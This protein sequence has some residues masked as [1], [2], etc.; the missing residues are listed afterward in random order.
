MLQIYL[1]VES[2][3][4]DARPGK[5]PI[6]AE[7]AIVGIAP[8]TARPGARSNEPFGS[9][10][11]KLIE[12]LREQAQQQI[13]VTNM[14][15]TPLEPGKKPKIQQ[16]RDSMPGLL[17]ELRVVNPKRILALGA[18]VAKQLCPDFKSMR[19]DHGTFFFNE[20]LGAY[21]IPTYHFSATARNPELKPQLARDLQRFF[22]LP[23]P[24]KKEYTIVQGK[25]EEYVYPTYGDLIF[26]DIETTGFDAAVHDILS[27]GFAF[28]NLDH[29]FIMP[30]PS[31]DHVLDLYDVV[32]RYNLTVVGHNLTFDLQFL[33]EKCGQFWDFPVEDTMIMAYLTGEMS[34]SLKHLTSFY[35]DRPGSRAFGSFE[36]FDYLTEDVQSTKEIYYHFDKL[37]GDVFIRGLCHSLVPTLVGMRRRGIY[38]DRELL[39]QLREEYIIRKSEAEE[40]ILTAFGKPIPLDD[41]DNEGFNVNSN[42]QLAK[43]FQERGIKL[44]HT[45]K[46]GAPSLAEAVMVELSEEYEEAKLVL[47]YRAISKYLSGFIEGYLKLTTDE[48]PILHPRLYLTST[49]TGRL[50]CSD[51]NLQQVPRVGPLKS[52][53][54]SR[55]EG[56]KLGL[57]DFSQA[58]LRVVGI[59]AGDPEFLKMVMEEDPHRAVAA[60]LFKKPADQVTAGERKAAKTTNFALLYQSTIKSAA[61]KAGI[62]ER[63]M[64][65]IMDD[66]FNRFPKL[67]RYI[68]KLKRDGIQQQ[69]VT[70]I[71]GRRRD[72]SSLIESEGIW[73]AQRKAV[74]TPIQG[75]ASDLNLIVVDY[76]VKD[77]RRQRLQTR[78]LITIHDSS[79][80]EIY[81]GE[82][83]KLAHAVQ[84]G[85]E[86]I[87]NSPIGELPQA[88]QVPFVGELVV[89]NSWAAIESTNEGYDKKNNLYFPMSSLTRGDWYVE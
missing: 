12:A 65:K 57:I 78:P 32:S 38:I 88:K 13:Y 15:K 9:R 20:F 17:Y 2:E 21:V 41:D 46:S 51:P 61:V 16:I 64:Q 37:L 79:M 54:I 69:Y 76:V 3:D 43:A 59:L 35:L 34:L 30:N 40:R 55:W 74:N 48:H 27:I 26:L 4:P 71:F 52:L 73:S 5:G 10:S 58:E 77:I 18:D 33:W 63:E 36:S 8:S 44:K 89:G 28:G 6:P 11:W 31:K 42:Q 82:E 50:S 66:F 14:I 85:F 84:R 68:D 29:V 7:Y 22:E 47:E 87:M 23:D 81:P 53:F 60:L 67:K 45:T 62:S 75:P 72:L 80:W 19:E 24:V 83:L 56:G 1:D 49:R 86:H 70:S 25:I 39:K